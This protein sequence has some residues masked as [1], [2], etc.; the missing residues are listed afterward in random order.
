MQTYSYFLLDDKGAY[1]EEYIAYS[2]IAFEYGVTRNSVA[3]LFNRAH[4]KQSNIIT[5]KGKQIK[6]VK[7]G[8]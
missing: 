2:D 6:Q 7:R 3:G 8:L 4:H 1:V 5:L